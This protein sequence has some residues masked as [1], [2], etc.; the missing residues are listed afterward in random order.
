MTRNTKK[1]TLRRRSIRSKK[2]HT[3][4]VRFSRSSMNNT[5]KHIVVVGKIYATWCGHCTALLPEWEKMVQF[6]ET[7]LNTNKKSNTKYVFSEIEQS[8]Q[9]A[10]ISEINNTYL[11]NSTEKLALQDGF[12]TLFKIYSGKV[13]YYNGDRQY[14]EMLRW[15]TNVKREDTPKPILDKEISDTELP[16]NEIQV[17]SKY[18]GGKTNHPLSKYSRKSYRK[19]RSNKKSFFSFLF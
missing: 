5:P 6:I 16:D 11:Q 4:R 18:E 17:T 12:P 9:D 2:T 8:K 7:K 15:Y 3:K 14:L 13:E 10:G 1:K 19:T